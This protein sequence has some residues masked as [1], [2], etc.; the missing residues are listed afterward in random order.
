MSSG[1][2]INYLAVLIEKKCKIYILLLSK[3]LVSERGTIR[4]LQT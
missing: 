3:L 2:D 4:G 1:F